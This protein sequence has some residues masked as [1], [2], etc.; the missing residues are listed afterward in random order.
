MKKMLTILLAA[1]L[2]L[3]A[4]TAC[5][6][7]AKRPV[8][9]VDLT[10]VSFADCAEDTYGYDAARYAVASGAMAAGD[11]FFYPDHAASRS[12]G[13]RAMHQL[14]GAPK[15]GGKTR[16]ADIVEDPP[17]VWCDGAGIL[18]FIT[19]TAFAGV[20]DLTREELAGMLYRTAIYLGYDVQQQAD[21]S[22]YIDG[23]KVTDTQAVAWAVAMDLLPG[24]VKDT[25]IQP[26]VAVS[27]IGLARAVVAFAAMEPSDKTAVQIAQAL[28]AATESYARANH[29]AM[30][31]LIER[32]ARDNGVASIQVAVVEKGV[33]TDTYSWGWAV[34][35]SEE[36]TADHVM[37]LASI[38]KVGIGLTA[39][40]LQ[41]DGLVDLEGDISKYWGFSVRNPNHPDTAITLRQLLMH[42]SS[43]VSKDDQSRLYGDVSAAL[44]DGSAFTKGIPGRMGYW[45]YNN[46]GYSVL[47]MTLELAADKYV[48]EILQ[49][50]LYNAMDITA[51][52][53]P[54]QWDESVKLSNVYRTGGGVGRSIERQRQIFRP[55]SPAGNGEF[56]A[57]VMTASASDTAKL[58]ALLAGDGCYEGLRLLEAGSVELM[59]TLDASKAPGGFGQGLTLR[60]RKNLYG[61]QDIYYHTGSAY[62]AYNCFSYDPN[63][64]DGIVVLTTGATGTKD[65]YGIYDVCAT[66]NNH[67]Y[68]LMTQ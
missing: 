1:G 48:D 10:T 35:D 55:D 30:Q 60:H 57:G 53:T 24:V 36:M 68:R 21:L 65:Q 9:K 26:G 66:I 31:K 12:E 37:R 67:F 45:N 22:A 16:F 43:L 42:T 54:G 46:Y 6:Q 13:T 28:P 39:L 19:G 15:A 64:G 34:K 25:R 41:E 63:T 18:D 44:R 4:M 23:H 3:G 49:E 29:D 38:S 40:I 14:C 47:G 27:R 11:G 59:E 52:Y 20:E 62:G 2:T 58:A 5:G 17:A 61:R 51:S 8:Q 7:K 56:F 32:A 33:L 50:R